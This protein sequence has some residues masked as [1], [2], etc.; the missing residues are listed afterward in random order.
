MWQFLDE[1]MAARPD[2]RDGHIHNREDYKRDCV[3]KLTVRGHDPVISL[4]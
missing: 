2:A 4:P 3:I 1:N